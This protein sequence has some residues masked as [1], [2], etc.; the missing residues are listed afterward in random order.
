MRSARGLL[1]LLASRWRHVLRPAADGVADVDALDDALK[2]CGAVLA[3]CGARL[4]E[5][6]AYGRA[7]FGGLGLEAEHCVR[8]LGEF[9]Q[10]LVFHLFVAHLP[11]VVR[12]ES[13]F[14]LATR[15]AMRHTLPDHDLNHD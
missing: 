5:K 13:L 10:Q 8:V 7:V 15:A 12:R 6:L 4:R 14:K 3:A 2:T 11:I 9:L 1:R